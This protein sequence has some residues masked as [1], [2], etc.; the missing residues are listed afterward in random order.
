MKKFIKKITY[1]GIEFTENSHE[2]KCLLIINR[3]SII[4]AILMLSFAALA[5]VLKTYDILYFSLPFCVAFSVAPFFNSK[6][7]LKFTKW[8]FTFTPVLCLISIC[9]YNSIELGDRFFFLTTATIPIIL[10][11]K[12]WVVFL[13]FCVSVIAFIF[14]SWYQSTHEPVARL[15]KELQTQYYYFT[16][17]SVF[18]VLFYVIRYFK[19]DSDEY[20][21]ELEEKNDLI[22]E[23][24]KEIT[25][26]IKYAQRIQNALL[27]SEKYFDKHLKNKK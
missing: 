4:L 25:D 24:N 27:P 12:N 23:K 13:I 7:W 6:G 8:F 21:K 10:F 1:A 9:F 20:E 15:P 3:M 11:R 22:T 14:T 17:V 2:R 18:I 16:L 19:R 5:P 26:S